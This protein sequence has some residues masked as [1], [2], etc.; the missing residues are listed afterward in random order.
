[1]P[2]ELTSMTAVAAR[3]RNRPRLS[4][5]HQWFPARPRGGYLRAV[6]FSV[7][8][9]LLPLFPSVRPL[10][11][12]DTSRGPQDA[13]LVRG[14]P[15]L[16]TAVL[17]RQPTAGAIRH[18]CVGGWLPMS[19]LGME[20]V[21]TLPEQELMSVLPDLRDLPLDQL[22]ELGGS[23]LAQSIALYRKRIQEIGIPLSS[24]NSSI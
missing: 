20:R 1:M 8:L 16:Y 6:R 19:P 23:V 4:C 2:T 22:A 3:V 5:V 21:I 10:A 9:L 12:L 18:S 13:L 17:A 15:C 24:F 7:L 14:R 11:A